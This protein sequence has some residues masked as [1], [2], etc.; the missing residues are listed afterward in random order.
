MLFYQFL[1]RIGLAVFQ[2]TE[3]TFSLIKMILYPFISPFIRAFDIV[4]IQSLKRFKTQLSA[5]KNDIKL[6]RNMISDAK[7]SGDS[8]GIYKAVVIKGFRKHTAFF[9]TVL[10]Y[11]LPAAACAVFVFTISWW[12]TRTFALQ[13]EYDGKVVG[14]VSEEAEYNKA[15]DIVQERVTDDENYFSVNRVPKYSLKIV[16]KDNVASV[17]NLCNSI[18]ENSDVQIKDSCGLYVDD[19]FI[20]AVSDKSEIDAVLDEFLQKPKENSADADVQFLNKIECKDGLYPVKSMKTTEQLSQALGEKKTVEQFY[21]VVSNDSPEKIARVNNMSLKELNSLNPEIEKL[22]HPGKQV[23]VA[24]AKSQLMLKVVKNV[25]YTKSIMYDSEKIQDPKKDVGYTKVQTAGVK[26]TSEYQDEVTYVDGVETSR[27][28]LSKTVLK[29]PV[30][31][32]VVV[33]TKKAVYYSSKN[34]SSSSSSSVKKMADSTQKPSGKFSWPAAAGYVSDTWGSGR[35]HSGIDI[36]APKGT[37]IYASDAGTVSFAGFKSDSY[38]IRV[39]LGHSNGYST[40]Y[41]HMSKLN[42]NSGQKVSK[43]QV[44]GYI[45]STGRS[46]GN[47]LHF[48]IRINGVAI[49]PAKELKMK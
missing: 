39:D 26:G 16:K 6:A 40:R 30:E 29:A 46:T 4:V 24:K 15:A 22:M 31:E 13:V 47:H 36:A 5:V 1:Y 19:K 44:I 32:V 38:G 37:P 28:N 14:Y 45:G 21:T 9:R 27:K 34:S 17:E 41:A 25:S 10:N 20:A 42:V 8:D 18:I 48:E 35:G 49:N 3:K 43:G 11:A 7:V 23:L 12:N 33:G 2:T